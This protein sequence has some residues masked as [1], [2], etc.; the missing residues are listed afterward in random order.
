MSFRTR[1]RSLT[2]SCR[3][4]GSVSSV[5]SRQTTTVGVSPSDPRSRAR[6][7]HV[8]R[9]CHVPRALDEIPKP[10]VVASLQPGDAWHGNDHRR[11]RH[12]ALNSS[13]TIRGM[14]RRDDNSRTKVQNVRKD[15]SDS[16]QILVV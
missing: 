16:S 3:S 15:S 7:S 1:R 13:R 5:T 8:R 6:H 9:H 4:S 11:F 2:T 10:V 14:R 12:T